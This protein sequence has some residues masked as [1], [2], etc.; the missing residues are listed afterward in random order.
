MEEYNYVNRKPDGFVLKDVYERIIVDATNLRELVDGIIENGLE[1]SV[2]LV[3]PQ[4]NS[5]FPENG[6]GD[7]TPEECE[8]FLDIYSKKSF[9]LRLT[10]K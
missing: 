3:M 1:K 7:L 8:E 10:I 9:K 2:H 5:L 4:A 6:L